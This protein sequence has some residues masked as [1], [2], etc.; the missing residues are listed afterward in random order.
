M[1]TTTAEDAVRPAADR[2]VKLAAREFGQKLYG[3]LFDSKSR[4][5][6]MRGARRS[7][8]CTR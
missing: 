5:K 1:A 8:L 2:V 4:G 3:N 6:F 7:T